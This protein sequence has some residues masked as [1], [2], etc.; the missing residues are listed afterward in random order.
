ME[1]EIL[2]VCGEEIVEVPET[3]V[4]IKPRKRKGKAAVSRNESAPRNSKRISYSL[5]A[6]ST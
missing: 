4:P 2:D 1:E 5:G 3:S 6:S